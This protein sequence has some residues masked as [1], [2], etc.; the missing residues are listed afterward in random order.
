VLVLVLPGGPDPPVWAVA[1]AA[2]ASDPANSSPASHRFH[3]LL[4]DRKPFSFVGLRG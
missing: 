4:I 3:L 1:G 2:I